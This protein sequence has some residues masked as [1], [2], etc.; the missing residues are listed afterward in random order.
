MATA[1][2]LL[3]IPAHQADPTN[4]PALLFTA[5]NRPYLA[6]DG[7]TDE[8]VIWQFKM[9]GD[10]ASGLTVKVVYSMASATANNIAIRTNLMAIADGETID[11]DG[12]S[13]TESSADQTVPGTAG[14]M[15]TVSDAIT[16]VTIAA[17]DYIAFRLG[18]EN[19]TSGTNATGDMEVWA[20]S[21]E[22]T[23][24]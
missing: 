22:Y 14:L 24:T 16:T 23:T 17:N 11:T 20:V 3:P 19:G 8:L 1:N 6:F 9:P 7:T 4:P 18:R 13:T 21:L 10:Y 15:K 2:L 12:W 5:S